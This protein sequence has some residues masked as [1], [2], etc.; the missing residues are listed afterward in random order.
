MGNLVSIDALMQRFH[1]ED[2]IIVKREDY[3]RNLVNG[4][5]LVKY[6]RKVLTQTWL[7][8]SEISKAKLWGN[9]SQ[10]RVYQ[11]AIDQCDTDKILSDAGTWKLHIIEVKRVMKLRGYE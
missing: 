6:R 1:N 2:L 10:K 9:V 4:M 3:E 8:F 7:K 5:P 11:I